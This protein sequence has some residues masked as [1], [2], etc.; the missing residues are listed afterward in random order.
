MSFSFKGFAQTDALRRILSYEIWYKKTAVLGLLTGDNCM[1]L[2][3]FVSTLLAYWRVWTWRTARESRFFR[4]F[5]THEDQLRQILFEALASGVP[6]DLAYEMCQQVTGLLEG[7]K[8]MTLYDHLVPACDGRMDG[9][10]DKR[11][12]S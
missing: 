11:R 3:L 4:R 6:R 9:Q 2:R 7:K 12:R 1:L 10:R 8:R 5:T